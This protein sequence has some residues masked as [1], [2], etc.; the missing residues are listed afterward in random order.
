MRHF[1]EVIKGN[2]ESLCD[3]SDGKKA[4]EIVLAVYHSSKEDSRSVAI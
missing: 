2:E 1:I 3:L 4:L